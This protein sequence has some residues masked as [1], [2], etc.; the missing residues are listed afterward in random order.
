MLLFTSSCQLMS[1]WLLLWFPVRFVVWPRSCKDKKLRV[2][3]NKKIYNK[4]MFRSSVKSPA[5]KWCP[6][7][8]DEIQPKYR[9]WQGLCQGKKYMLN[10]WVKLIICWSKCVCT[11]AWTTWFTF[12]ITWRHCIISL[13][14]K[15]TRKTIKSCT[16]L[17]EDVAK[18]VEMKGTK[19]HRVT[20]RSNYFWPIKGGSLRPPETTA[21]LFCQHDASSA[22][23]SALSSS[24]MSG[25]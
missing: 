22:Q 7:S 11:P 16:N 21:W 18:E 19:N 10:N 23:A 20:Y 15:Y 14:A 24:G 4:K 2:P 3:A 9:G 8:E 6:D 1:T 5:V 17:T 12:T 25:T 13:L